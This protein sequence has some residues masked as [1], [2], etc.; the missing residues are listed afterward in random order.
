MIQALREFLK[1]WSFLLLWFLVGM[2]QY[3]M[4]WEVA[5]LYCGG[6]LVVF[7]L[8][9]VF[10]HLDAL[11]RDSAS[12]IILAYTLYIL[13][14]TSGMCVLGS[15]TLQGFIDILI[16]PVLFLFFYVKVAQRKLSLFSM[17]LVA[18]IFV[19]FAVWNAFRWRGMFD[20]AGGVSAQSNAGNFVVALLPF[21]FL[22]RSKML[23]WIAF[24]GIAVAIFISMKRSGII[25]WGGFVLYELLFSNF[26]KRNFIKR[27]GALFAGGI[28]LVVGWVHFSGT[29]VADRIQ[30]RLQLLSE[31]GGSGRVD[32]FFQGISDWRDGALLNWF[33]G[34]GA[35]GSSDFLWGIRYAYHNDIAE[36]LRALG[37]LGTLLFICT[38]SILGW[39]SFKYKSQDFPYSELPF[40][41]MMFF[42]LSMAMFSPLIGFTYYS[43]PTIALMG[44]AFASCN[45]QSR[46]SC[47]QR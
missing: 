2:K 7:C 45:E 44:A 37:L 31:D 11:V 35:V 47:I 21:I 1:N 46:I 8:S 33:I 10:F 39:K 9:Y 27:V 41:C 23:R 24:A 15:G 4:T 26:S 30:K 25:I 12:K 42:V 6:I 36:S 20:D 43:M 19:P 28:A 17:F 16:F 18:L 29:S 5:Q 3:Y 13:V 40:V 14:F 32:L 34:N 38:L 22:I